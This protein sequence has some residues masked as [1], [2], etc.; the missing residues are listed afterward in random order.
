MNNSPATK[1]IA[2]VLLAAGIALSGYFIGHSYINAKKLD[3]FITVKGLA[4][5]TVPSDEAVWRIQF[6]A[7][8]DTL[9]AIYANISSAQQTIS[10]FLKQQGFSANNIVYEPIAITDNQ[11]NGYSNN[12][13]AKRFSATAA[14]T[15]TTNKV[16]LAK[17]AAQKTGDLVKKGVLISESKV[18]YFYTELNS[19][20]P[21]M[22][23]AATD[24]A[25]KAADSFSKNSH[26]QLGGIRQASQG[27]FTITDVSGNSYDN[28]SILKKVRVVTTMQYYLTR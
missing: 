17:A 4:E 16:N 27:L 18:Q 11:A 19:I 25:K 9:T 22:L 6:S 13:K 7:A 8:D 10:E 5:R 1:I 26:S 2:A 24:N 28:T 3:R 23:D 21:A 12:E 14:V 20:K 15:L